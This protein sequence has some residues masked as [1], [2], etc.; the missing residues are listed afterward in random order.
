MQCWQNL[1]NGAISCVSQESHGGLPRFNQ[2]LSAPLDSPLVRILQRE[3]VGPWELVGAATTSEPTMAQ[4][5]DR[6]MMIY[7]QTVDTRRNRYNYRAVDS[8]H[9]PLD[10]GEKLEWKMDG[11]MLS[12]PGQSADYTLHLYSNYK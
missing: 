9:V 6:S 4:S 5:R 12:I 2:S 3:S 11:E 8:N 7:A 1:G 10:L